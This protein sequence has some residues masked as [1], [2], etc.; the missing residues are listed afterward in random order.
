MRGGGLFQSIPREGQVN[1]YGI[2]V[3]PVEEGLYCWKRLNVT[4]Y[5]AE[6]WGVVPDGSTD[7]AVAIQR[8]MDYAKRNKV[9]IDFPAGNIHT[10][11]AVPIYDNCGIR[12]KG[13]AESTVFYKTS[14]SYTQVGPSYSV[15]AL[16]VFIPSVWDLSDHE[17]KSYCSHAHVSKCMF[18]RLG[19]SASTAESIAPQ[20]GLFLGKAASPVVEDCIFEG[21]KTGLKAYN[22]FSGGIIR[23]SF[24]QFN[25]VGITGFDISYYNSETGVLYQSGTSMDIRNVG[26]RGYQTGFSLGRLQHSTMTDCSVE[27]VFPRPEGGEAWA[28]EFIDPYMISMNGCATEFISGGQI[29]VRGFTNPSFS[30]ALNVTGYVA[31]DQQNPSISTPYYNIDGGGN[32]LNVVFQSCELGKAS[33]ANLTNPVVGSANT[34]V[35]YIGTTG[36]D[37]TVSGGGSFVKL[38]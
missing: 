22:A 15:D 17:M 24:V 28:F 23:T 12:G 6:F 10:S 2:V 8:A 21:G 5:E 14:N 3:F 7:N 35:I 16:C 11:V 18:R 26:I 36:V 31:I 30:A 13:R 27:E 19:M 32:V 1:D 33:L 25:R 29:K 9:I 37:P 4:T 20:Y 38:A 34:K